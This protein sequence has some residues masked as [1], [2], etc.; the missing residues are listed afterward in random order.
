MQGWIGV[1]FDGTLAEYHGFDGL[2]LGEPVPEMID[3]VKRWLE[4]DREVKIVTA[5]ISEPDPELRTRAVETIHDWLEEH[6]GQVLEV[7]NEKDFGMIELWDDRCVA[8]ETNTGRP[9]S[10]SRAG[11]D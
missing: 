5:R 1:D 4:E 2:N 8:V 9:L 3:R 11:L 6:L 7:T 10:P